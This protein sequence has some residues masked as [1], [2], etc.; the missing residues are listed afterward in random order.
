MKSIATFLVGLL[1]LPLVAIM[2]A[3]GLAMLVVGIPAIA[4]SELGERVL[5]AFEPRKETL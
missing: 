2:M 3:F 4:I 1:A 5:K